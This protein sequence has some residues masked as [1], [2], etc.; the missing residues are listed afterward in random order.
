MGAV[1]WLIEFEAGVQGALFKVGQQVDSPRQLGWTG[2]SESSG[3]RFEI[4][5]SDSDR[6]KFCFDRF[7][8]H[9]D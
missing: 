9:G 6:S 5:P 1:P 2:W 4:Q 7:W 8:I 3:L